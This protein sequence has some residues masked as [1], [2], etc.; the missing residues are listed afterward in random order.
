ME[1]GCLYDV[2]RRGGSEGLIVFTV[3]ELD[4]GLDEGR[5][6]LVVVIVVVVIIFLFYG[7]QSEADVYIDFGFGEG[8][9]AM[10]ERKED[11]AGLNV[12]VHD[13]L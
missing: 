11:V 10:V 4:G 5:V 3:D 9:Y 6:I 13:A 8:T 1:R 2:A 12:S 7:K